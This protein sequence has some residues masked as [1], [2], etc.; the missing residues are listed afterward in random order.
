MEAKNQEQVVTR[1]LQGPQDCG[2]Y[3]PSSLGIP[4]QGGLGRVGWGLQRY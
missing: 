4:A 2:A 3:R 1:T